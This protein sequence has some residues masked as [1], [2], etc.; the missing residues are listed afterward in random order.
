MNEN[1]LVVYRNNGDIIVNS[2]NTIMANIKIFDMRGRL[3][4]DKNNVNATEVRLNIG[5]TRQVVLVKTI[6]VEGEIITKKVIN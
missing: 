5:E 2:G 4:L 3:L 6:L 1:G